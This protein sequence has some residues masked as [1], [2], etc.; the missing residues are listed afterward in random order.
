MENY[1]ARKKAEEKLKRES[2]ASR[3][4][5]VTSAATST[6]SPRAEAF[7]ALAAATQQQKY[8]AMFAAVPKYDGKNKEEC[9]VWI[10]QVSSLAASEAGVTEQVGRRSY[11]NDSWYR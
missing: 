1:K 10:N 7:G 5:L 11:D 6:T 8:D 3:T 2:R 4:L 9:A